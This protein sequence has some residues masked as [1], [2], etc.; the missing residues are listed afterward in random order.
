MT[1]DDLT[2]NAAERA[3]MERAKDL[4]VRVA[5]E[6]AMER[7]DPLDPKEWR[8]LEWYARE[9]RLTL[10][11]AERQK[12]ERGADR[13]VREVQA[14]RAIQRSRVREVA[15]EPET[16][17]A[18]EEGT[19]AQVVAAAARVRH[20]PAVDL[21]VAAGAGREMWDEPCDRWI[22]LPEGSPDGKYVALRVTG[23]S[24]V[25]LL[26]D[27]DTILVKLGDELVPD[28]V[29]VARVPDGGYVVKRVGGIAGSRVELAS[30]NAD[31]PPIVIP[32]DPSL[33]LGTVLLRWCTHGTAAA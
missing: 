25:P 20:A 33:V 22:P 32:R 4:L 9:A 31:Y 2:P 24:M 3:G 8:F 30:L 7:L 10:S 13:F 16:A 11:V 21:S 23:D 18:W 28:A 15:A 14:R 17:P 6:R 19:L 5:G 26:H 12:L 27:G 1:H 29:V